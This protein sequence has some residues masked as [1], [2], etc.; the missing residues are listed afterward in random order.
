[1]PPGNI[2][3]DCFIP[4]YKRIYGENERNG[5]VG[6]THGPPEQ[7][8][9]ITPLVVDYALGACGLLRV[10]LG[11]YDFNPRAQ[12]VYEKYGFS[13]EGRLRD[14]LRWE[15]KWRDELLMAILSSDPRPAN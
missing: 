12:R 6:Q 11:V 13:H 5:S 4:R 8:T 10:I 7:R 2:S 3:V 15:G 14:A 9:E 1:V